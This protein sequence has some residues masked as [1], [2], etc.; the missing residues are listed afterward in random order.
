MQYFYI[1]MTIV[2]VTVCYKIA[3]KKNRNQL[4]WAFLGFLFGFFAA[5][6]ISLLPTAVM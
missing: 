2:W 6:A 5:I 1:F 4:L 3:E